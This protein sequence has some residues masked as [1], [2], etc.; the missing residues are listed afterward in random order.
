MIRIEKEIR[1]SVQ[2]IEDIIDN[3]KANLDF[4][5]AGNV[6]EALRH[7]AHISCIAILGDLDRETMCIKEN[8]NEYFLNKDDFKE[9]EC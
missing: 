9:I 2:H 7:D 6:A 3:V 1:D 5:F 8:L 4:A